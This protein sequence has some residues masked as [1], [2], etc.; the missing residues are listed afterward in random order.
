MTLSRDEFEVLYRTHAPEILG[1]LRR[2]GAGDDAQ[3]LLAD[4]FLTA[5][6]RRDDLPDT[7]LRRAWLFG[8]ARRLLLAHGRRNPP[9]LT[10]A[11]DGWTAL[12]ASDDEVESR[13]DAVRAALAD[14]PDVDRELLT[15]T[16]WERLPVVE[17]GLVLGLKASAARVR[18][19]RV[20]SRLARDP[21]LAALLHDEPVSVVADQTG[22]R[23][24]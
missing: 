6:R 13:A 12:T 10:D 8:V 23:P 5:W 14:L 3:D 4:T 2:R 15:M 16:V 21:R 7:T 1:Y 20:R 24:R 19:H 11:P 18:L 22:L 9:V 17:A